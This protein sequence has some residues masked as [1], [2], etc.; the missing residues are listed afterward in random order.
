ML[1]GKALKYGDGISTDHITPGKYAYLRSNL[2][3]L[4]KHTM[5]G[6]DPT[7]V[8]R[9]REGDF[10]VG[11]N[12][13]GLGSSREQAPLVLKMSGASAVLAKSVARIF[14]RNAIN[15]GLPVLICDTDSINEGD[16]LE[17]DLKAGT[18][19]NLTGGSNLTFTPLPGV[20]LSILEE[21]GL[22]PYLAKHGSFDMSTTKRS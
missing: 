13:F 2:P 8:S 10:V 16:E 7:F 20:M 9:V 12:N 6:A 17:I 15:Q 5:E 11:G 21:G 4:V 19:N 18:I 22:L 14:F 3:E 1:R